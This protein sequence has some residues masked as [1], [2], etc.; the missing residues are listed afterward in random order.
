[1]SRDDAPDSA[2]PGG[3]EPSDASGSL[4]SRAALSTYATAVQ[5]MGRLLYSVLIGHLGS[6]EL[7]GQTN[8]SLSLS[9]L[10]SQLWAA[11]AATAGTR[12]VAL[13]AT[14]GDAEGAAT[15]ARHIATQTALIS[16][17]LP[18]MVALAGSAWLGFGAAH[19]IGTMV[20]AF[21]YSMYITLRGVQ[22]GALRFR[23]VALWDTVAA[24]TA[25]VAV[26]VVLALDLTVVAL[27][28]LTLGY[29]LFAVASWPARAAGQVETRLRREI[30]RFI[31]FGA[32]SGLASGGLLQ[33]SQ[34]V[35]HSF[36]GPAE[37]GD[38]AAALTLATPASMLSIALSTVLV[39]PLVAAA[40]R[41]DQA[42]VH[43]HSDA[44]ARRLTAIF[45]GLFGVLVIVSPLAIA[46]VWGEEYRA[47]ASILPVLLIAVMLTSI[48][49]GAA[50]TLQSTRARG[51]RAVAY[52]NLGGLVIS[53]AVWPFLAPRFGT[54]GVA[55]GYLIG[56]GA[57]SLGAL[58]TVWWVERHRWVDLAA[59]LLGG[60]T[61]VIVLAGLAR[62]VEGPAGAVA[63][64]SAAILF[65]LIW[66][67]LNRREVAALWATVR[68]PGSGAPKA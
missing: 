35:A 4:R 24:A 63:Q 51:P 27:L 2:A 33:L 11:P 62:S 7:L 59:K 25:L 38:F 65:A 14:L 67:G 56:A 10:T 47:A 3:D 58:A 39:P 42:A 16:M 26:S 29:A 23:H 48:A 15:V 43:S 46:V 31:F 60:I 36:A 49:L 34:L 45:V 52:L 9:V 68:R 6:R 53:L 41:G 8:T 17:V 50:T 32:V 21:A 64:V 61:I 12:F 44:I 28:P 37:A 13:K 30:D 19:T 18:T 5:G 1:V 40:G 54:T 55:L 22:Y 20:L 66:L 57:A